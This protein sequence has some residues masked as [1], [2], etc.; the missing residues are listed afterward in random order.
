MGTA[1]RPSLATYAR[2]LPQVRA[3]GLPE[4]DLQAIPV[5]P[6]P[7]TEEVFLSL[8]EIPPGAPPADP[9]EPSLVGTRQLYAYR[10]EVPD[11]LWERLSH[12]L[13]S[14][15][16]SGTGGTGMFGNPSEKVVDEEEPKLSWRQL[17]EGQAPWVG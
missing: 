2:W 4:D 8:G 5:H 3:L 15:L 13:M 1:N 7:P 12:G 10:S 17:E 14:G 11:A 16:P 9:R 6:D